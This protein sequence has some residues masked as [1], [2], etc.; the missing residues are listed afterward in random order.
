MSG[1]DRVKET[2]LSKRG[3]RSL[4]TEDLLSPWSRS[5]SRRTEMTSLKESMRERSNDKHD[6]NQKGS[7][8][9]SERL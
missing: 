5:L 1:T 7:F 9:R 8:E 4:S 6:N 2:G 3:F